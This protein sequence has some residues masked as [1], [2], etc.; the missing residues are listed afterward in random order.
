[1]KVHKA[2]QATA[3][4][5]LIAVGFTGSINTAHSARNRCEREANA[6]RNEARDVSELRSERNRTSD[7]D[8]SMSY[9]SERRRA[10]PARSRTT[11]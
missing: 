8:S 3:W 2:L 6:A 5:A 1:M 11:E 9:S 7:D 4:L 10:S